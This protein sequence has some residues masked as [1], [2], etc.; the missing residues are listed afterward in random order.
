MRFSFIIPVYNVAEY[1]ETCVTSVIRQTYSDIE[2]ILVD[3]GSTDQS[4][5]ICDAL[6]LRD[7][8]VSVIHQ[9]NKGLSAARNRGIEIATGEYIVFLDSDDF[10]ESDSA[11]SAINDRLLLSNADVLSFNYVKYDGKINGTPYLPVISY[12]DVVN[13]YSFEYQVRKHIWIACAWNKAVKRE[14][15]TD[16]NMRFSLGV[17]SEDIDWCV[18]LALSAD[19]FDYYE[20]PVVC[21]RQ[22]GTSISQSSTLKKT[23]C[24][25]DNIEK[26]LSLVNN[27]ASEHRYLLR[28]YLGYQIGTALFHIASLKNKA[29]RDELV[30]RIKPYRNMLGWSNS[31]KIR[32]LNT[33]AH[34]GG[35]RLAVFLLRLSYAR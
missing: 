8:R 6:M 28:D 5:A 25:I 10:W 12:N 20:V 35:I 9:D 17:T 21:Y 29:E 7:S 30:L 31:L 15:F 22:R 24:L 18:R 3:D 14:L 26:S 27:S 13:K 1:L 11:L 19:V 23:N 4:G 16:G 2:I 33:I 32:L 34:I